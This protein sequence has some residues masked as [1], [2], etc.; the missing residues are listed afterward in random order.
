MGLNDQPISLDEMKGLAAFVRQ[1]GFV[2]PEPKS[3]L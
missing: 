2:A 3:Q 1:P